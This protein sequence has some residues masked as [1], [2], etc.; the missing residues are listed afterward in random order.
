MRVPVIKGDF[1]DGADVLAEPVILENSLIDGALPDV[2]HW[3][4]LDFAGACGDPGPSPAGNAGH[5]LHVP[6]TR[7]DCD[8]AVHRVYARAASLSGVTVGIAT[9]PGV[10][11]RWWWVYAQK[12]E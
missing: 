12:D 8:G 9:R 2:G 10:R 5:Y 3:V 4:C 7:R 6:C 1:E 11:G